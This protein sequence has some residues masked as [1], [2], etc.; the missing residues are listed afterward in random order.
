MSYPPPPP[1][2]APDPHDPPRR[3][4]VPLIAVILASTLLLCGG[5]VVAGVLVVRG[6][7]NSAK[8]AV[9]ELPTGLPTL[10]T[11]V[12]GFPTDVP[13]LPTDVPG[14]PTGDP[15][16]SFTVHYEIDGDGPA[17]ITYLVKTGEVPKTVRGAKLPWRIEVSVTGPSL[18]SV[19]ALRTAATP[20]SIT[21]RATVD[22]VPAAER[23]REG[24]FAVATCAK[25]IIE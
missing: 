25:L 11:D 21:C 16:R 22:G 8:D 10:P 5:A 14:L 4:N 13:G 9:G 19:V 2:G 12:P 1:P 17:D 3:S 6:V 23:T 24:P 15:G 7:V 18:A 20:G